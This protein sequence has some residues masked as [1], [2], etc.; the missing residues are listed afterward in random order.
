MQSRK[1]A[2]IA[3]AFLLRAKQVMRRCGNDFLTRARLPV[4]KK[5]LS[6]ISVR[7]GAN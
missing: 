2:L 7:F 5:H 4:V 3:G 1:M 6:S